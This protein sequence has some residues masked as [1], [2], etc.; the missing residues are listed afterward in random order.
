[1]FR[2][3]LISKLGEDLR[4]REPS[5]TAASSSQGG[6]G[7]DGRGMTSSLST[8]T[9]A[10]RDPPGPPAVIHAETVVNVGK[11]G[12]SLEVIKGQGALQEPP[13]PSSTVVHAGKDR[14]TLKVT[15]AA[16]PAAALIREP[17]RP[18]STAT[19][20]SPSRAKAASESPREVASIPRTT[21]DSDAAL[22]QRHTTAMGESR[23]T[24]ALHLRQAEALVEN[25]KVMSVISRNGKRLG[26]GCVALD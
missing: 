6:G 11:Q 1:M 18:S 3:A 10:L 5:L 15:V 4:V 7:G 17:P 12:A 23:R 16:G 8:K 21:L 13:R 9:A 14:S 24:V 26:P 2:E 22:R 25:L 19:V 20:N